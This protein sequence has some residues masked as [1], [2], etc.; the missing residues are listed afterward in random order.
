MIQRPALVSNAFTAFLLCLGAVGGVVASWLGFPMPYMLG[1]LAVSAIVVALG[2]ERFPASYLFPMRFRT[3]FIGVIG[4][5]IGAQVDPGL[6]RQVSGMAVSFGVV[7]AFV[8]LAQ[9]ANYQIFH[10]IGGYDRATAFFSGSP[11]G[12]IEAITFG[13]AAGGDVRVMTVLQFLRIIA[14]VTILPIIMTIWHGS[15][16]GSAAGLQ[17]AGDPAGAADLVLIAGLTLVGLAGG[18]VLRL[19]AGQL[20]GP[21]VVAALLGGFGLVSLDLPGWLIAVAQVVL[22]VSLG[23]RFA[24]VSRALLLKA[25]GL[26]LLSVTAMLS[27][28]GL[29]A[30]LAHQATG[31]SLEVLMISYAPGGVTEMGLIALSL[32][33][34]PALVTLHHLFRITV[35][36]LLLSLARRFGILRS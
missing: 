13:E 19:P 9:A 28:G 30:L 31:A 32:S 5:M 18:H 22:G 1:S 4:V 17:L 7:V 10:R 8:V 35:T 24:G 29:G 27:L 6:A 14:V 12:L 16:V 33:V 11:G 25:M 21:L 2:E 34:N 23:L 20:T 36:V 15:P 3:F 26:S